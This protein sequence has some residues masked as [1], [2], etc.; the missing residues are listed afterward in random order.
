MIWRDA[1]ASAVGEL[2]PEREL[3]LRLIAQAH[4]GAAWALSSL[5]ARY[6]P[7]VVRYLVRLTGDQEHARAL[8]EQVFVRMARRLR[9]PQRGE[10]LRLWLLRTATEVGL[11]VLRRPA[12]GSPARLA[13]PVRAPALLPGQVR[14]SA[15]G[16]VW[17]ALGGRYRRRHA[18]RPVPPTQEF[19]WSD[20]PSI[21]NGH[22]RA[23]A[24]TL[25]PREQ[26]RHRLIRAV[27][28]ELTY[29][30][31]Q[32]LALHLVAGLNQTEVALALG[33]TAAVARRRIVQGLQLFGRRYEATLASLGLPRD[34]A[35]ADAEHVQFT[36]SGAVIARSSVPDETGASDGV[37]DEEEALRREREVTG[38]LVVPNRALPALEEFFAM[39]PDAPATG[40]AAVGGGAATADEPSS[41]PGPLDPLAA[42]AVL[43]A[44]QAAE[45][46]AE[47]AAPARELSES[48]DREGTVA[49][50]N[51]ALEVAALVP[52]P[53]TTGGEER[54]DAA[55]PSGPLPDAKVAA[56]P[57]DDAAADGPRPVEALDAPPQRATIT[58]R[59]V[60]VLA[61]A[62][63]APQG[64]K[65][66]RPLAASS[67]IGAEPRQPQ[68]D[69]AASSHTP[70]GEERVAAAV[71]SAPVPD[72]DDAG[73]VIE[74]GS[75]PQIPIHVRTDLNA[76]LTAADATAQADPHDEGEWLLVLDD[77][78]DSVSGT[79]LEARRRRILSADGEA[80]DPD[81]SLW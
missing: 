28:G 53:A 61:A 18:P 15:L 52:A 7:P 6:Q 76:V 12:S 25:S 66:T 32:C 67:E 57:N 40:A 13:A 44:H 4:A 68:N 5:V 36:P 14:E 80:E 3:E 58:A 31:A 39:E 45:P 71:A 29:S 2:D 35:D 62:P 56:A 73:P 34:F 60:P 64:A 23:S 47:A 50:S 65:P 72:D 79:T 24:E 63:A 27:L 55:E 33:I 30:E 11:D 54:A 20:A 21:Q 22:T 41:L 59:I 43:M 16:R 19:V 17:H 70:P 51:A 46:S 26:V 1:R 74:W 78:H 37:R 38:T 75:N 49:G 8:A 81:E 9:G 42:A 48:G 77:E 69:L 10:H